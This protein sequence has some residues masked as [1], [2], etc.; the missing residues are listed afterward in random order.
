[1]RLI[2]FILWL[3]VTVIIAYFLTDLKIGGKTIKQTIDEKIGAVWPGF[4]G[5][6]NRLLGVT[7][8]EEMRGIV[9]EIKESPKEKITE[10]DSKQLEEVLKENQ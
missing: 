5:A 10:E 6:K 8:N 9:S 1:M 3:A 2:K 7:H 4:S